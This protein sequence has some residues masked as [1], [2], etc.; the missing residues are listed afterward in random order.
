[1]QFL[2]TFNNQQDYLLAQIIT[3]SYQIELRHYRYFLAVAEELHF[4]KAADK[5]SISQPGLS[6]QIKE[7]EDSLGFAL[8]ERNNRNV[9]LTTAGN[10]LKEELNSILSHIQ[11]VMQHAKHLSDGNKGEIHLGYVGSAMQTLIPRLLVRYR[12]G[13]SGVH[14]SLSEMDNHQQLEGLLHHRIDVGFVRMNKVPKPLSILPVF[15]ETFSLV[16]PMDHPLSEADLYSLEALR[17]ESF[18]FFEKSYSSSYYEKVL[19]IFENSGFSP[20]ISHSSVHATTIYRLVENKF[21]VA[22]VPTSL[23]TNHSFKVKFIELKNIPQRAILY[24]VWHHENRN[25]M[26]HDFLSIVKQLNPFN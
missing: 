22:I 1:M 15:E 7:M 17:D 20:N 8:F 9:S 21:G 13:H 3:M 14:F 25:P 18:I 19:S 26:L 4:K 16:L 24:M 2:I 11:V 10:Y 12:E 5:L 6:R 23:S